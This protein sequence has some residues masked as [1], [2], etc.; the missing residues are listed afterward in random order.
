MDGIRRAVTGVDETGRSI[1]VSDE[2]VQ[3]A[4]PQ[5]LGGA[6]IIDLFGGRHPP[7]RRMARTMRV[8]AIFLPR[9]DTDSRPLAASRRR[10]GHAGRPAAR[11]R[12]GC[13]S[14][15]GLEDVLSS[16]DGRHYTPTIDL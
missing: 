9:R 4:K 11:D 6:T 5:M 13:P 12:G 7:F 14:T 8:G 3:V 16:P 10:N 2:I 15:P 1:F